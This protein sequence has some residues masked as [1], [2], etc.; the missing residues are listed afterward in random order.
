MLRSHLIILNSENI[1][2]VLPDD[3]YH[4]S[5]SSPTT[6]HRVAFIQ[7]CCSLTVDLWPR[8]LLLPFTFYSRS[9]AIHCN[10]VDII[11]VGALLIYGHS[12]SKVKQKR[13]RL[14]I[15]RGGVTFVER[16]ASTESK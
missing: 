16:C 3:A 12:K 10:H 9:T 7:H 2:N 1:F 14:T 4:R 8:V 5:R 15:P 11:G 13:A 6:Q